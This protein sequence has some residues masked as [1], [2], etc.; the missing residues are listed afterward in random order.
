MK[1]ERQMEGVTASAAIAELRAH[2]LC[3][4]GV[5][6]GECLLSRWPKGA[7]SNISCNE[8]LSDHIRVCSLVQPAS[9]PREQLQP[10]ISHYMLHTHAANMQLGQEEHVCTFSCGRV[11]RRIAAISVFLL[12]WR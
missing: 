10:I 5:G 3:T 12:G 8:I 7:P 6:V 4:H 2:D 11:G 1:V 9:M